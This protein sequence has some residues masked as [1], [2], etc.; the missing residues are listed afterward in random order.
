MNT[1]TDIA[2]TQPHAAYSALTHGIF[3][4]WLFL[5]RTTPDIHHLLKP[6]EDCLCFRFIPTITGQSPPNN[7]LRRVFSLPAS[8]G[9]LNILSPSLLN[10][11]YTLSLTTTTVLTS[12]ILEQSGQYSIKTLQAQEQASYTAKCLRKDK[13]ATVANELLPELPPDLNHAIKLSREK[14][15]SSWVTSLPISEHGFSLHKGAFRDALSLRYGWQPDNTPLD[16]ICGKKI[17]S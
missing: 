4:L 15:A 9:G 16:C 11:E 6:I 1:L 17:L 8:L 7:L 5:C 12:L 13:W 14:G 10:S 2:V 3:N